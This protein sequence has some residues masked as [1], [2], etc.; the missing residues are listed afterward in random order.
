VLGWHRA[1]G[2]RTILSGL[3]SYEDGSADSP[4][5]QLYDLAGGKREPG[6]PGH[7]ASIGPLALADIDGDGDLDL[8]VGGQVIPGKYPQPASSLIF[9]FAGE[10]FE[11]DEE[12]SR[13]LAN[14]GL[15]NSAVWS[16]LNADGFPELILACE[17]G[18]IRILRNDRGKL[19]P[20]NPAVGT[21]NSSTLNQLTGLW[22]SVT[23][24]DFDGDGQLDIVA[25]NWGLNSY[26]RASAEQPLTVF[27][28]DLADRNTIDILET[29][30]DQRGQLAPRHLRDADGFR[31]FRGSRRVFRLTSRG[32]AAR[33]RK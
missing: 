32:V 15:V 28:G 10:K 13:L 22:Q 27:F 19:T 2:Q 25:G 29:E 14:I 30:F 7:N 18:P 4:C 1:A 12:N 26:W 24:G 31:R 9:R 23:T 33:L 11:R 16:D 5:A 20:W 17:W 6:L 21:L 3:A 8:F